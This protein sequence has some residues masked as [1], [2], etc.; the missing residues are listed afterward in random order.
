MK[1]AKNITAIDTT[2]TI[3]VVFRI[4]ISNITISHLKAEQNKLHSW[5]QN[6]NLWFLTIHS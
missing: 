1:P 4:Q 3:E 5:Q 6:Q 2:A